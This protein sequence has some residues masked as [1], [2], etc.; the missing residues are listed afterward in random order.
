MTHLK[1]DHRGTSL[2]ATNFPQWEIYIIGDKLFQNS[3]LATM[4]SRELGIPCYSRKIPAPS[5]CSGDCRRLVLFDR[6]DADP[7]D[8]L[9]ALSRSFF[10]E[11]AP[12]CLLAFFNISQETRLCKRKTLSHGIR[13]VF[14]ENES[15]ESLLKGI[16]SI[17]E[18]NHWFP[19]ELLNRWIQESRLSTTKR[20][21]TAPVLTRREKEVLRMVA[22]GAS[23][24]EISQKMYISYH[25]VKTHLSNIYKKI[26]VS[27]RLQASLWSTRN[28]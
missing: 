19:R 10:D 27:N 13:G 14:F 18:N 6:Q 20:P 1:E 22:T 24:E 23:N 25:T 9:T 3:L 17:L 5:V 2:S 21:D 7:L 12:D 28:L 26:N 8:D 11:P 15:F 4:L 16:V